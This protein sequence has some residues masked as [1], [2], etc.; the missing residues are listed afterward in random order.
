MVKDLRLLQSEHG[1]DIFFG[2]LGYLSSCKKLGLSGSTA[3]SL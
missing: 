2:L 1:A 3:L